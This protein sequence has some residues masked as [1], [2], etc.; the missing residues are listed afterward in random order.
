MAY[1]YDTKT[2]LF[3]SITGEMIST[4]TT[5][6]RDYGN[7]FSDMFAAYGPV[8]PIIHLEEKLARIKA[9]LL[10]GDGRNAVAG[11]TAEDSLKD[12]ACYAVMTLA[13]MREWRKDRE[14]RDRTRRRESGSRDGNRDDKAATAATAAT[15][16]V[17]DYDSARGEGGE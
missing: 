5:K 17:R 11:E 3:K 12:L 4:Y 10:H 14:D 2:E 9:I 16:P 15:A 1:E 7:S 8:Y 6:N 13:E